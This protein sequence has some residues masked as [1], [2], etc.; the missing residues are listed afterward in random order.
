M[1]EITEQFYMDLYSVDPICPSA[2]DDMASHIP[3]PCC[4]STE[5]SKLIS[6]PFVKNDILEQVKR[7]PKVSSPGTDG[8]S[9]VFLNLIFKHPKYS[10]LVLRVY[11]DALSHSLFPKSWL[12]AC[13]CL[14]PKKRGSYFAQKLETYHLNKL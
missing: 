9:Y 1:L 3:R 7:T 14:L 13:I 2:F 5:D 4:L 10:D 6:S 12:E 8:L 11:N